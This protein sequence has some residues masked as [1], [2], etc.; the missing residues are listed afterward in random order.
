MGYEKHLKEELEKIAF[1]VLRFKN[2]SDF[3]S[4]CF[5]DREAYKS[6]IT[7]LL[8]WKDYVHVLGNPTS[9]KR[10]LNRY[11]A[12]GNPGLILEGKAL[13][14]RLQRGGT[15]LWYLTARIRIE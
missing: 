11:F 1:T 10:E 12:V 8:G 6:L 3:I 2:K 14:M 9:S 5:E 13:T 7:N 4:Y 15:I